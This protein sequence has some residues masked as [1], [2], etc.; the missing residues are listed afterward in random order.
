MFHA[1]GREWQKPET[2]A[3]ADLLPPQS[4]DITNIRLAFRCN[5]FIQLGISLRRSLC[6]FLKLCQ[7]LCRSHFLFQHSSLSPRGTDITA[8]SC[9][10]QQ[11]ST[12][13]SFEK[14]QLGA[15]HFS[16]PSTRT[17]ELHLLGVVLM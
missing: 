13:V 5:P 16:K 9:E 7:N 17:G 4:S 3:S 1:G 10:I 8:H 11:G 2:S 12:S 15:S 6:Q 14:L